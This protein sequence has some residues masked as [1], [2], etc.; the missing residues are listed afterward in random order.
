MKKIINLSTFT[1]I[2]YCSILLGA[3][4]KKNDPKPANT[5]NNNTTDTTKT[6]SD[7][8]MCGDSIC[9]I[10]FKI[11]SAFIPSGY[12]DTGDQTVELLIDSIGEP[13][14]YPGQGLRIRYTYDGLWGWGAHFLN[15]NNWGG[16]F[17]ITPNATKI[18]LYVKSDYSAN[19][20]FN[21]FAD[22]NYGK[23]ELYKL[24][25]PITPVWQKITIPLLGKPATFSAPLNIVIDGITTPG[26]VVVV[27]IKDVLIE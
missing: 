8:V 24:A 10:P 16:T 20:T 26:Q 2:V 21:A 22:Q 23:V 12:Y 17:K 27:D 3:C 15:N 7:N 6:T 9:A 13:V 1:L 25:N 14:S 19:V 5:T 4:S 11:M 18:T